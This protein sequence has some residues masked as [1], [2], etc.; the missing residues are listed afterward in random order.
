M[1]FKNE[2]IPHNNIYEIFLTLILAF[3]FIIVIY[4]LTPYKKY[5]LYFLKPNES[6]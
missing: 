2:R 5:D 1:Y 3:A 4:S 6:Y